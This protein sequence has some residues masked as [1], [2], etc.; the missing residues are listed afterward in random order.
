MIVSRPT[1]ISADR[2]PFSAALRSAALKTNNP[3]F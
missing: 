1:P 3:S 2:K